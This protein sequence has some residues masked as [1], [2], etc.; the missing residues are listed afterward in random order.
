MGFFYPSVKKYSVYSTALADWGNGLCVKVCFVQSLKLIVQLQIQWPVFKTKTCDL[1]LIYTNSA[2][3]NELIQKEK[4]IILLLWFR[5]SYH[6]LQSWAYDP[7]DFK[8][9]STRPEVEEWLY[10]TFI[11][12]F[13]CNCL[14]ILYIFLFFVFCTHSYRI[15]IINVQM[16]L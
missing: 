12:T 4:K 8:G 2:F 3:T 6:Y 16:G 15:R 9:V 5:H 10:F 11:F 13:F 14:R 7:I 1:N